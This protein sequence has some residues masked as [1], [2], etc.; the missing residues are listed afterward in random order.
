MKK[1]KQAIIFIYECWVDF[2]SYQ[3]N[4]YENGHYVRSDK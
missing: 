1:I 4:R 3:H 2:E